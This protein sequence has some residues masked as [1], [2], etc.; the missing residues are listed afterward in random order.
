MIPPSLGDVRNDVQPQTKCRKAFWQFI[1]GRFGW[2][3]C[4]WGCPVLLWAGEIGC[5]WGY[6]V[7]LWAG[8]VGCGWGEGDVCVS[9]V[10][11]VYVM[12]RLCA[13]HA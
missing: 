6:S 5:G 9:C 3:G 4:H 7:L 1:V 2:F 10:G 12:C 8:E 11:D 13:F